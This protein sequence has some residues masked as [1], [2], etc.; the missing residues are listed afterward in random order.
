MTYKEKYNIYCEMFNN[1]DNIAKLINN[2]LVEKNHILL[3]HI[4]VFVGDE[5]NRKYFVDF[6]AKNKSG[7]YY[8]IYGNYTIEELKKMTVL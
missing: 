8:R 6:E 2:K 7:N 3:S 4:D 1:C 5:E